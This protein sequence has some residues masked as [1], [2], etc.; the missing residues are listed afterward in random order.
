MGEFEIKQARILSLLKTHRLDA[1]LLKQVSSFA[2]ATCGVSSHVNI[3]SSMGEA[4]LLI[5]DSDRFLLTNNIEATRLKEETRLKD[6]G[7]EFRV[8]HWYEQTNEIKK[9][10]TGLR[11][12]SDFS[13]FQ[14][15]DLRDEM[16][17]LR[18]DLT[19]DE[20]N[21]FRELGKLC[22][23]AMEDTA[24]SIVPGQTEHEIA[25]VLASTA[26]SRG[27]QAIVNLI[28]VDERVFTHRHPLPT[29]KKLKNYAM[30]VLCGRKFGLVCSI[31][32]FVHFGEI[33]AEV[34]E[35]AYAVARVDARL[36]RAT[37]PGRRL[38]EIFNGAVNAYAEV[39]FPDEWR[40]HHQG[41][42]AG[43]EPRERLATPDRKEVV[44]VGQAYAWNP[45]ITGTKSEDTILVGTDSNEVITAIP[46]WPT[47]A[48]TVDNVEMARP[49]ILEKL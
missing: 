40:L 34:K 4:S 44:L 33:P 25:G 18:A 26:E 30:L 6:Q 32:R 46:E 1:L 45:S 29:A 9:L 11:V 17:H 41:G 15:A 8:V 42:I 48:V 28:A 5:T 7:W 14:F 49:T 12:G 23:A 24:H 35:K 2:W 38:D 39:G 13:S 43:Y 31:T 16:A 19:P 47:Y 21:R 36:I 37:R 3:A 20:G 27:V 22:A 10:I